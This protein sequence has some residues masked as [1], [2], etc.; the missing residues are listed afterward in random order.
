M[1]SVLQYLLTMVIWLDP[2]VVRRGDGICCC[3]EAG[4]LSLFG[5]SEEMKMDSNSQLAQFAQHWVL[6]ADRILAAGHVIGIPIALKIKRGEQLRW[7]YLSLLPLLGCFALYMLDASLKRYDVSSWYIGWHACALALIIFYTK[8]CGRAVAPV[9]S[10]NRLGPPRVRTKKQSGRVSFEFESDEYSTI[11]KDGAHIQYME[12]QDEKELKA[13]GKRTKPS[14]S[15]NKEY[16]YDYG[17]LLMW[18]VMVYIVCSVL[19]PP[20]PFWA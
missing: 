12:S 11:M 15:K 13:I 19:N 17:K 2:Y 18:Y 14:T 5:M 20:L 7:V 4:C 8:C 6:T 3:Y 10:P 1:T 16:Q 9:S